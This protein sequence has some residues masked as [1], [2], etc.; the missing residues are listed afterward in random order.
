MCIVL[1][2]LI[3]KILIINSNITL[4]GFYKI[5]Q[6]GYILNSRVLWDVTRVARKVFINISE[7]SVTTFTVQG[8][9]E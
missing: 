3:Y 7:N 9:A 4:D 1:F 6:V 2:K 8:A 5:P